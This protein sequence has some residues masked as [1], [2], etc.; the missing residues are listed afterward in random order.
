[1]K[2]LYIICLAVSGLPLPS[3]LIPETAL[4]T[5]VP[6]FL[7]LSV[8]DSGQ[9]VGGILPGFTFAAPATKEDIRALERVAPSQYQHNRWRD[10]GLRAGG[11][12]LNLLQDELLRVILNQPLF[13]MLPIP[14]DFVSGLA[15]QQSGRRLPA[16]LGSLSSEKS[17]SEWPHPVWQI[18]RDD[19]Q[20][21]KHWSSLTPL[22]SPIMQETVSSQSAQDLIALAIE[23]VRGELVPQVRLYFRGGPGKFGTS[24]VKRSDTQVR[25]TGEYD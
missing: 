12:N 2:C 25:L 6:F 14:V 9:N 22:L 16:F 19:L 15:R 17:L 10:G 4:E 5:A 7:G 21:K 3:E 8:D 13:E 24:L 20:E 23:T 11:R 1:M 18:W